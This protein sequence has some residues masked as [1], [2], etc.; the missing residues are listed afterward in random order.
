MSLQAVTAP[1]S[2]RAR[3]PV[4]SAVHDRAYHPCGA[5]PRIAAEHPTLGQGIWDHRNC[6]GPGIRWP[7]SHRQCAHTYAG[8]RCYRA[9]PAGP[10]MMTPGMRKLALTIHLTCSVGWIGAVVAY[11]ALGIAAVP[12]L[13]VQRV[14]AAWTAMDVVGWWAIVPLTIAALVTGLLMSL[15]THWGLF[16][17]YWVLISLVLTIVST[18]VLVLHMP[19]V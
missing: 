1:T 4:G 9:R 15:G 2:A 10:V 16:R 14:R 17:H 3:I 6:P 19:T 11:L 8:L 12:S 7:A 5:R 18:V 13:E